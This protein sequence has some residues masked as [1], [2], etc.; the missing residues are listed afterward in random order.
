ME[1]AK[2]GICSKCKT[3][4]YIHQHHILPKA[5]FGKKGK[6]ENLCPNCHTHF[7]QY[8]NKHT[9]NGENK[10]EALKIWTTWFKTVSV[11]VTILS[12]VFFIIKVLF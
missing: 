3:F 10:K 8:S 7:H 1:E 4:F 11:V 5:R 6:R 2:K 12:I 9:K